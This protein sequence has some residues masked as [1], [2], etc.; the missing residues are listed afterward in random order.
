MVCFSPLSASVKRLSGSRT[1]LTGSKTVMSESF[2][3]RYRFLSC[4]QPAQHRQPAAAPRNVPPY[5]MKNSSE[6]VRHE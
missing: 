1:A 6:W 4:L 2:G 5:H 3:I